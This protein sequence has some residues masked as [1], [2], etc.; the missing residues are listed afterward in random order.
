MVEKVNNYRMRRMRIFGGY[1]PC[2]SDNIEEYFNR[3]DVQSSLHAS[4]KGRTTNVKWK[5]CK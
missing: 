5:V 2:F 1:D 4:I 3:E